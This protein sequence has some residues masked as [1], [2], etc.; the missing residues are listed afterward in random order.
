VKK[1]IPP[2]W[3]APKSGHTECRGKGH[4]VILEFSPGPNGKRRKVAVGTYKTKKKALDVLRDHLNQA[5][6]N[7]WIAAADTIF[8][9]VAKQWFATKVDLRPQTRQTYES[10]LRCHILPRFGSSPA[11]RIGSGELETFLA[12]LTPGNRDKARM[13]LTGIFDAAR[14][15]SLRSDN[16]M[17]S[18]RTVR[19]R[20]VEIE[21]FTGDELTRLFDHCRKTED[22]DLP[23]YH[24]TF[25]LAARRSEVAALRWSDLDI[26]HATVMIRRSVTWTAAGPHY[27]LPKNG[28]IRKLDIDDGTV[29]ILRAHRARQLADKLALGLGHSDNDLIFPWG[30][31]RGQRGQDR[32]YGAPLHSST[33]SIRFTRAVAA[34][35]LPHRSIHALR[36]SWATLALAAGVDVKTVSARL[37]HVDAS[38]TLNT[39]SHLIPTIQNDAATRVARLISGGES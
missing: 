36:H 12:T 8:A 17:S 25:N 38:V 13:I 20:P 35:G 27:G 31:A 30:F 37:G 7:R 16:P 4:E 29:A 28:R 19:G 32:P 9:I 21:S 24:V 2:E 1:F 6:A 18:V 11:Q 39:Y 15:W 3:G 33:I 5:E 10:L 22:P 26:D 34:A 14:R 23:L